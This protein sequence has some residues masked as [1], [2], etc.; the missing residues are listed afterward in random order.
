M[1][2]NRLIASQEIC[3]ASESA[4]VRVVGP[5]YQEDRV[6]S[7]GGRKTATFGQA[8]ALPV[9]NYSPDHRAHPGPVFG[10]L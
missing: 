4:V 9:E 3:K 2:K 10:A 7:R 5:Q 1:G 8:D 6:E